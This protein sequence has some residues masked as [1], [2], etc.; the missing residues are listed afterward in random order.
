MLL[1]PAIGLQLN[2]RKYK[3]LTFFILGAPRNLTRLEPLTLGRE[4]RWALGRRRGIEFVTHAQYL[5]LMLGRSGIAISCGS[6]SE[7]AACAAW[8]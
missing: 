3:V 7:P 5:V 6:G 1:G 8:L 4:L 2:E